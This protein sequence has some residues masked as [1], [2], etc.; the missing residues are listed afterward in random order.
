MASFQKV[1]L[2]LSIFIEYPQFH[3]IFLAK[4]FHTIK[5][6]PLFL[7]NL[8]RLFLVNPRYSWPF[9]F[10]IAIFVIV[11]YLTLNFLILLC[12]LKEW[13][14]VL[15]YFLISSTNQ[16]FVWFNCWAQEILYHDTHLS[17]QLKIQTHLFRIQTLTTKGHQTL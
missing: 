10:R 15:R 3:L 8:V 11:H 14:K 13:H 6:Y 17:L 5:I 9:W 4:S 7:L 12:V 1:Q 2:L 16:Q